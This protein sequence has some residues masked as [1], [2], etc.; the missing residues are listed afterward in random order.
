MPDDIAPPDP[1]TNPMGRM[2]AMRT[3]N[4]PLGT[5][6]TTRRVWMSEIR[7]M[8]E[9]EAL[10]PFQRAAAA[11]DFASPLVHAGSNSLGYIN[12]DVTLYLHRKP[13]GVW[14]G[15]EKT[16]HQATSGVAVGECRLYDVTGPIGLVACVALGQRRSAL[17]A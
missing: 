15:F 13:V 3:I 2:W 16:D 1:A 11:C 14:I 9:G 5:P 12:S 4:G 8:V 7:A 6:A 10:T 17:N